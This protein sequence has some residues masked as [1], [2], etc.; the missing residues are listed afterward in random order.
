MHGHL[1]LHL[2]GGVDLVEVH[3]DDVGPDRMALDLPNQRLHRLAVYGEIDDGARG[4]DPMERL[5]EGLGLELERLR[6]APVAVDHRGHLAAEAGLARRAFS[7]CLPRARREAHVFRHVSLSS[8]QSNN[9]LTDWF[10]CS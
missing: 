9:A 3:V 8:V 7:G 2:L 4:L 1:E 6:L 5:F 10:E